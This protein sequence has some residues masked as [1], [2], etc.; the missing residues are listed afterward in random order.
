MKIVRD[1]VFRV[2][3]QLRVSR[4][5]FSEAFQKGTNMVKFMEKSSRVH[6]NKNWAGR[7]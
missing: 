2:D 7:L 3:L 6:E 5:A 1:V 4:G